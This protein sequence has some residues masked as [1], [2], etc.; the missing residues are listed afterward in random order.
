MSTLTSLPFLFLAAALVVVCAAVMLYQW[1]LR[2]HRG[3]D[4]NSFVEHF[5][6]ID[7]SPDVAGAVYDYYRGLSVWRTF[8]ISP[9]DNLEDVFRHAPEELE[10]ALDAILRRLN[11]SLPLGPELTARDRKQETVSD[12]V[13]LVDWIAKHQPTTG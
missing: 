13:M 2:S 12:V 11:L 1:R 8:Q 9:E 10:L 3:L 4:R 5:A 7:A 6:R